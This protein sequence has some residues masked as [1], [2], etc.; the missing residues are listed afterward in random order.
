MTEAPTTPALGADADAVDRAGTAAVSCTDLVVRYGDRTAVDSVSFEARRGEVLCVLGPNGAGKTSTIECLEG[1]RR[2]VSGALRVLGLDPWADHAAVVGRIGVMLQR[3]GVYPMLAPRQALRLFA[4]YYPN[5]EDPEALVDLVRLRD[6]ARTPWRHLSGGEQARLSLALALVG[7]PEVVFLDE[8]T[9]GV[10]PEGRLSVR[11]VIGHLRE[12][13]ACV[14]LTTHEMAEAERVADR[15]LILHHGRIVAQG[16]PD[17]L[18][19]GTAGAPGEGQLEISFGAPADLDAGPLA[20]ALGPGTT[21]VEEAPGRYRATRPGTAASDREIAAM[22]AT[23]TTWLAERGVVLRDLRV[24]R[25]LEEAYLAVV[26]AQGAVGEETD[27]GVGRE[28]WR[29]QPRTHAARRRGLRRARRGR[30]TDS[31]RGA[32]RATGGGTG[33]TGR[34]RRSAR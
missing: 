33:R 18:G 32:G 30:G 5:P 29:G 8:P 13:G 9:A 12:Q 1:Y 6:V 28:A 22:A 24:G 14:V 26:G 27:T 20:A 21:V 25:S 19:D 17:A 2:P 23:V 31:A 11:D 4:A 10:D 15:V 34:I 3:G 16:T 7:R